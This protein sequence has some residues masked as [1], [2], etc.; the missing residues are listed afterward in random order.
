MKCNELHDPFA[1]T[2]RMYSCYVC[3][4]GDS[5]MLYIPLS[6]KYKGHIGKEVCVPCARMVQRSVDLPIKHERFCRCTCCLCGG[7]ANGK[8]LLTTPNQRLICPRCINE[9]QKLS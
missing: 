4:K 8:T 1:F 3:H 6:I 9:S 7:H 2:Y 5:D